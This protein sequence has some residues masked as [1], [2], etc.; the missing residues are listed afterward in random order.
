[1][2]NMKWILTFSLAAA[3]AGSTYAQQEIKTVPGKTDQYAERLTQQMTQELGLT[4][5]QV[6]KV[7]EI[8]TKFINDA[9]TDQGPETG[10]RVD[11]REVMREM[12]E[13][14]KTVLSE[15]QYQRWQELQT[16]R[17]TRTPE[18][19]PIQSVTPVE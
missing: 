18:G 13:S 8:N 4:D 6:E 1:M 3:L 15:E 19:Q 9:M 11:K 7:R 17:S 2:M 10:E 14:L 16:A 12:Q 5:E